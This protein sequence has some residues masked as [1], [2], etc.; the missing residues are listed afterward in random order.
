MGSGAWGGGAAGGIELA[1]AKGSAPQ[2]QATARCG[3]AEA[4]L[5]TM[6]ACLGLVVGEE[7]HILALSDR[8]AHLVPVIHVAHVRLLEVDERLDVL[9]PKLEVVVRLNDALVPGARARGAG[10]ESQLIRS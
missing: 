4:A 3:A 2:G 1:R 9:L 5:A 10:S 6:A 7:H 8:L